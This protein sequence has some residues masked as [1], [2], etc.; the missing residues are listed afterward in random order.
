MQNNKETSEHIMEREELEFELEEDDIL[1]PAPRINTFTDW[2]EDESDYELSDREINQILIVTQSHTSQSSRSHKHDGHDRTGDWITRVKLSQDHE[3]VIN[4]G[5][6]YYEE[7][8]WNAD[9][10]VI[11]CQSLF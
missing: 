4:D 2:S 6:T 5:L 3:Q 10:W 8:L 11:I 7:D 9:D 1:V